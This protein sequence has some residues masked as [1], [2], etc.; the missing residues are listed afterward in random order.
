MVDGAERFKIVLEGILG[1]AKLS[2]IGF[3]FW[4]VLCGTGLY[5]PPGSLPPQN[6]L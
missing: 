6:I 3:E 1:G 2:A 4:V 5:G